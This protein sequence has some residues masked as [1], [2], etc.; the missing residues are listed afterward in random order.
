MKRIKEAIQEI[1]ALKKFYKDVLFP[2]SADELNPELE[3][4]L[5]SC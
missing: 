2:G 5:K 4:A 3:K 1:A